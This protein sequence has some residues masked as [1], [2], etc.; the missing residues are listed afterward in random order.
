MQPFDLAEL[1][2]RALFAAV[3]VDALLHFGRLCRLVWVA[4]W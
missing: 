1:I 4:S 3:A 2:L